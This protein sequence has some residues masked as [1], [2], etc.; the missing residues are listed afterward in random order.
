MSTGRLSF[1]GWGWAD[2]ERE[3]N[4]LADSAYAAR[5]GERF[6]AAPDPPLEPPRL[7]DFDLPAPRLK[8][9]QALAELFSADLAERLSHSVGKSFPDL[10]GMALRHTPPLTDL[11]AYPRSAAEVADVLDWASAQRAAVIP[12]GAGSTVVGG[13]APAVGDRYRGVVTL[14]L[15][16]MDQVREVD[17]VSRAARIDGGILGPELEAQLKPHGYT[18]RHFPQSFE[19]S[20]LGGWVATRSGGHY[21][22]LYTHVDDFVESLAMVTPRGLMETR[23]LPGSGAGPSP[24]R[25][26]IGSEGIL[27]VITEAWMRVQDRPVHRGAATVHFDDLHQAAEAVRAVSQ[28]G[29]YPSNLRLIDAEEAAPFAGGDAHIVILGF[30]S[31]DHPVDAWMRRALELMADH[32]GREERPADAEGHR[33]GAAGRWREHFINAGYHRWAGVACGVVGDTF[34]TAITWERF[35]EFHARVKGAVYDAIQRI[36]GRPG[37]VTCRFTHVYPDG[38]APYFTFAG[39]GAHGAMLDQWREI[40]TAALEAV[41]DLGG[42]V[43]HHHAIGRDHRRGYDR[44]RP[45]L[46]AGALRAAKDALDPGAVMNPGVLVDP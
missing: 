6:G 9:P 31:A 45:E 40:K 7:E 43:T 26:M 32:G 13:I 29:L 15:R 19:F 23:R 28:T 46:F 25:M 22:T 38:P 12:Y 1:W 11:V 33:S 8:P 42:T 39:L 20:T 24:D 3:R 34:E 21:A 36:T 18:L 27:G 41:V 14:D 4:T 37:T 17:T 5:V 30:E 16:A 44:Q 35:P 10:A 2:G